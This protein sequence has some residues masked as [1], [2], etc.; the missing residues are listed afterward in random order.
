M[1]KKPRGLCYNP[2]KDTTAKVTKP[3]VSTYSGT[4]G[5]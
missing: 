1:K 2:S 4:R 3:K 5:V